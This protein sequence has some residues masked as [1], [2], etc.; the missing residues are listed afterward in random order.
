MS[1]F[2]NN[3]KRKPSLLREGI[4]LDKN[5]SI[6]LHELEING[7]KVDDDDDFTVKDEEDEKAANG[8]ESPEDAAENVAVDLA[9]ALLVLRPV[10]PDH[11]NIIGL[12]H[13]KD[14]IISRIVKMPDQFII[15]Q[16]QQILVAKLRV[17]ECLKKPLAVC[18][19]LR[20]RELHIKKVPPR[21]AGKGFLEYFQIFVQLL[22]GKRQKAL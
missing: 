18:R 22:I 8:E 3:I 14:Q 5:K 16:I 19:S 9:R 20:H 1:I 12:I 7:E 4:S 10:Q 21:R 13:K 2:L 6:F 17:A 11:R 15:K